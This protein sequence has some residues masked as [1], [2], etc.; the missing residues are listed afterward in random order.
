[1]LTSDDIKR[2]NET[3]EKLPFKGKGYV[4]VNKRVQAF[5]ELCPNGTIKT[6]IVNLENGVVTM[7]AEIW[8][9]E[10]LL[11]TGLAQEKETS[12]YINKTSFIENCET[13]AV[14]RALGFLGIGVDDS[15]S[16]ADELA[17]A[18]TQQ[19]ALKKPISEK[20]QKVLVSM[21]EKRGLELKKVLNGMEL[22]KVTGEAYLDAVKRLEKIPELC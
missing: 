7:R 22:E 5:R 15:I 10:K 2:V 4:M 20:E 8:D 1:M 13:S 14:G 16:T 3:L 9:D 11:A 17:N 12:S 18:L 6:E 21:I 19:E